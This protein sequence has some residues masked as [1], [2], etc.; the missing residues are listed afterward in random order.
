MRFLNA[1]DARVVGW[2]ARHGILLLRLSLGIIFIWFGALKFFPGLSPAE[3]LATRTIGVLTLGV[4]DAGVARIMIAALETTIGLGLLTGVLLRGVLALLL[5]QL[6][7]TMTPIV[8]FPA[9][10]FQM[11]PFVPTLEG[12]YIFKNMVLAGAGLV[13][14]ATVRGGTL[15]P[16]APSG[17]AA[18]ARSPQR[19]RRAARPPGSV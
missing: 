2:M 17:A 3:D 5:F 11:V 4:I 6:L 14:G 16:R 9:E 19:R 15:H 13:I 10:V 18:R 8:L 1:L 12:Q 7:G